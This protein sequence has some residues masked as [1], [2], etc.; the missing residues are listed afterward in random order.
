MSKWLDATM[1]CAV[2][3]LQSDHYEKVKPPS[4]FD[5]DDLNK[6]NLT[7][8]RKRRG[9][10]KKDDPVVAGEAEGLR[11][12]RLK[13][14]YDCEKEIS[15]HG[16]YPRQQ[17]D[18]ASTLDEGSV[19]GTNRKFFAMPPPSP[20]RFRHQSWDLHSAADSPLPI[21]TSA[22]NSHWNMVPTTPDA[23]SS[24]ILKRTSLNNSYFP[25]STC[26]NQNYA[27]RPNGRTPPLFLQE[28]AHISS[29]ACAVA[30]STL[31]N[32]IEDS[33]SPMD[34]YEPGSE[35]PMSDPDKLPR[36]LR[37]EF[38]HRFHFVTILRNWVGL[39][40]MPHY[41]SKYNASRPI[42]VIG[43]V[44][45]AEV[46]FLQKARGPYAKAQLALFWLKELI[47]REHLEGSL[48]EVHSAIISRLVQ[49]MSDGMIY[50]NHAR[51]IMYVPF[52]FPHAQLSVFFT[53][54]MV[55][56]VPFLMDA[57]TNA[58]WMGSILSFLTVTCL[59]G[60][61]EVARELENPFRN[62]PNELPL[63]T[64]QAV[65]NE[66][67]TTMFSGFNPDSFWDAEAYQGVL[68]AMAMGKVYQKEREDGKQTDKAGAWTAVG[69]TLE[70]NPLPF[71]TSKDTAA[72]TATEPTQAG[73][74]TTP[75]AEAVE[76][77]G[78]SKKTVTFADHVVE[79]NTTAQELR[80]VLAKQALEIEELV[81]LLDEGGGEEVVEGDVVAD[82]VASDAVG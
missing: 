17:S 27:H 69:G 42:L 51:K 68:E 80:E 66:A 18:A 67:L 41:R 6:L 39:D 49:F 72:A 63:C 64:L 79:T 36:D 33:E 43:G 11:E 81:R 9:E 47:I 3:H 10:K 75:A 54:V 62:V 60:L 57:Y 1:H 12:R 22:S 65:Y 59:V 7:R 28:L 76:A 71:D 70:M 23:A 20:S 78:S 74:T 44:S 35:W 26:P 5:H 19:S 61:H 48:G 8:A 29:L 21:R 16:P 2:F 15:V 4:F 32:D 56:A 34:V 37:D 55:F 77:E 24:S 82:V 53:A 73:E 52:P 38:Q 40:R 31:R 50:Y 13:S 30:L 14:V 45:D 46:A 58:I 25:S